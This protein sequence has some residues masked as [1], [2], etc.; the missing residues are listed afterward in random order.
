MDLNKILMESAKLDERLHEFLL[1]GNSNDPVRDR[2]C[3]ILCGIAFEHAQSLK[4]LMVMGNHTSAAGLI[5]LQYEALV[6]GMWAFWAASEGEV[7]KLT[8]DLTT[9][10]ARVANNLPMMS[11]MLEALQGKAPKPATD[12][13]LEFRDYSWKPL[14]SF[15][16]GGIHAV[17]RNTK[18]YPVPL[19]IQM[20]K[21]SNGVSMMAAMVLV[22]IA[23]NGAHQG[24]LPALQREYASCLPDLK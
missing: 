4:M 9:E 12:L 3:A 23:K 6:R 1:P 2:C 18:G 15:V 19:L 21:S 10:S 17:D 11:K 8:A 14:S 13:L 7:T 22:I 20:L 16:H 24:K 5:R